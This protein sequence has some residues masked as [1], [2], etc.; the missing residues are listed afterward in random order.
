MHEEIKSRL[1]SWNACWYVVQ[2]L[3]SSHLLS[4]NVKVEI[5]KAIILPLVVYGCETWSL[6]LREEHR[7]R[8]FE[9]RVLRGIFRSNRDEVTG[10]W[11]KLH[12]GELHNLYLPPDIIRQ[13]KSRRMRWAGH[14]GRIGE[15]RTCTGF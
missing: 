4:R 15:G 13:I 8:V 7:L 3:L 9:N 6:T 12:N 10:D 14:V 2:S 11:R 1:N 5:Y